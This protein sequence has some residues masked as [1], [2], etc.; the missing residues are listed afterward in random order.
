MNEGSYLISQKNSMNLYTLLS[1]HNKGKHTTHGVKLHTALWCNCNVL[2]VAVSA[3]VPYAI[4]V[5]LKFNR[6][7]ITNTIMEIM[8]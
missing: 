4:A 3:N 8:Q 5:S 1:I 2:V 7:S 6:R